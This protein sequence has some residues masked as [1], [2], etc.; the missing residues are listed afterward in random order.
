M[1]TPDLQSLGN[2]F[3]FFSDLLYHFDVGSHYEIFKYS[4]APLESMLSKIKP[5]NEAALLPI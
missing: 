5:W 4:Q 2:I 3:V 1:E